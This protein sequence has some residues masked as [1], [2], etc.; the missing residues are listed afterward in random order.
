[1]NWIDFRYPL[2][3]AFFAALFPLI[4]LY[5]L[6]L[7]RPRMEVPSLALWQSV[8][9]DQRVNSPFQKFRRNILLWLQLALLCLLIL[10]LMQPSFSG[11]PET[12][13]YLPVLIDCSASM[14]SKTFNSEDSR[15]DLAKQKAEAL[16]AGLG[17]SGRIALFEFSSGGRRLTEFT[18]DPQV[19]TKALATIQPTDRASRLDEVLRMAGA[20][21][22]TAPVERVVILTDGNLQ[23]KV[24]FELPFE[25]DIQQIEGGSQNLGITEMSARRTSADNPDQ[26]DVF[27]R[28]GGSGLDPIVGEV[29]LY[30][31]NEV[32]GQESVS[33]SADD[34]ERL[35]FAVQS[36]N[37]SLLEARL[38]TS[39]FDSLATDNSVWL[40]LPRTRPLKIRVDQDL[41]SWRH[42]LKIQDDV[43]VDAAAEPTRP[44][45]DLI[46]TNR[47]DLNGIHSPITVY[48]GLIP[49][50]LQSLLSTRDT[51]AEDSAVEVIDW[52]ATSPILQHVR[53]R[54]VQIG[55][56]CEFAEAATEQKLEE[57][58]YEILIHAGDGPL[59]LQ[60]RRGLET[61]YV[62][63][64]STGRSTLPYRLAFPIMVQNALQAARQQA[65]LADIKAAPTGILPT[66][67]VEAER[68]YTIRSPD[69]TQTRTTSTVNGLLNSVTAE[70]VGRYDVL[71]DGELV[72]SIGTGLLS[73]LETSLESVD[74][75]QFA[76]L[77][78]ETSETEISDSDRP[79][80]W[81]L[82]LAAF[83]FLLFEWWYFQRVKG[84]PQ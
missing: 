65:G 9:N 31:D 25:L 79:L 1:M 36:P 60:R 2:G 64:F 77:K 39:E 27:V 53:L 74:Q 26:W 68:A 44:E 52:N 55:Q 19:L 72:T 38:S 62:F 28:V 4:I 83:G 56:T 61:E 42:A 54:G 71:E 11:G 82:A 21:S 73:P 47:E 41:Y 15:L 13:E 46:I 48:D 17:S 76:E 24:D 67:S 51:T 45:Y 35:V 75:I 66:L 57:A 22:R 23:N 59:L 3:A 30:Q 70:S 29:T 33:A 43:E 80:W 20:Y 84:A 32:I 78:I 49:A 8:V 10:A 50:S 81:I 63:T 7:K 6:K 37:A 18:N 34:S 58:G 14:S 16:I 69:G 40:S 5:F 12:R